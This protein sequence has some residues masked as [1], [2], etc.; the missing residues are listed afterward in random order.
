MQIRQTWAASSAKTT[1]PPTEL[2]S[3]AG[4]WNSQLKVKTSNPAI[5]QQGPVREHL[6]AIESEALDKD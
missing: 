3:L 1:E 4:V 6:C 2:S 5:F